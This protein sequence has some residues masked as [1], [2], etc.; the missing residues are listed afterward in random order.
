MPIDISVLRAMYRVLGSDPFDRAIR[1]VLSD[2]HRENG[3]DITADF[4]ASLIGLSPGFHVTLVP[5]DGSP[6]PLFSLT[7]G[8]PYYHLPSN[9]Q[10]DGYHTMVDVH[11]LAGRPFLILTGDKPG[12]NFDRAL[13]LSRLKPL[14]RRLRRADFRAVTA[15]VTP[16]A[17][18]WSRYLGD[19]HPVARAILLRVPDYLPWPGE[20]E[21]GML[22]RYDDGRERVRP[23]P[24]GSLLND[25]RSILFPRV[26][27]A[28]RAALAAY[29]SLRADPPHGDSR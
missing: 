10:V 3:D 19:G 2:Y 4:H 11:K 29:R 17:R 6:S 15:F 25:G 24:H 14:Y 22:F 5:F 13:S 21:R 27:C 26:R 16:Q 18:S 9:R 23:D 7:H 1:M 8:V 28:D 20:R 12:V